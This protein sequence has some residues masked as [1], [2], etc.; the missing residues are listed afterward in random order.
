MIA[1]GSWH[2]VALG[3]CS[4]SLIRR[5]GENSANE[6]NCAWLAR[7]E[8]D[9]SEGI[10][11]HFGGKLVRITGRNL[12]SEPQPNIR[13]FAGILRNRVPWIQESDEPALFTASKDATVVEAIEVK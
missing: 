13:L 8:F 5:N 11:L 12:D 10:S 6:F 1:N 9:P 4:Q 2:A 3:N 7:A